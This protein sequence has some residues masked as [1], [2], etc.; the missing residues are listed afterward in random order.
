MHRCLVDCGNMEGTWCGSGTNKTR[1]KRALPLHPCS[2]GHGC[3]NV[4]NAVGPLA[5]IYGVWLYSSVSEESQVPV[6]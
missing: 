6:W 3:N 5:A 1:S 4:S 2:F